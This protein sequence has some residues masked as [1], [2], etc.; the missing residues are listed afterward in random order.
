MSWS[1]KITILIDGSKIGSNL[2]NFPV[3]LNLSNSSGISDADLSLIF[4]E[5]GNESY[6]I[7][8][9]DEYGVQLP[10]EIENWDSTHKTAQLWVRVPS[11]FAGQD[12]SLSL[13]YD[14]T[15]PSN[16]EFVGIA[17]EKAIKLSI[18]VNSEGTYDTSKAY[19][20]C[21]IKESDTSY[22]MWYTGYDGTTW[23]ILYCTSNDGKT[24]SNFQ[25]VID[26]GSEG[27]HDANGARYPSVVKESNTLYKMWY[28]GRNSSNKE[29]VL[30]ATSTDGT[31]WSNFQR[32]INTGSEGTYDTASIYSLSVIKESDTSY[33]IWYGGS[34]GAYIRI[35]YATS[36]N[37]TSWSN[38]QRSIN[39]GSE[40]T[41]D[42]QYAFKPSVIKESSVSYKI[43]Y[44]GY[45]GSSHRIIYATSTDGIS[46]SNFQ[47]VINKNSEGTYDT[48]RAHV[49]FVIKE[50]NNL[51]KI[52]YAGYNGSKDRI[53]YATSEDG[54][55]WTKNVA[56][57][58]WDDNFVGVWHMS[59]EPTGGTGCILDSTSNQ[60]NGTP[61]GNMTASDLVDGKIGKALDFDGNDDYTEINGICSDINSNGN[62]FT[63]TF[64]IKHGTTLPSSDSDTVLSMHGVTGNSN[65]AIFWIEPNH[66]YFS[67]ILLNTSATEIIRLTSTKN[68]C[69]DNW[70]IVD[71][72]YNAAN[73]NFT[74]YID[75]VQDQ[76]GTASS[77]FVIESNGRAS[78]G[79]E[80]DAS[81][82][83]FFNGII[84]E[85]RVSKIA[86]SA[87]WIKATYYSNWDNLVTFYPPQ[88][89]YTGYVQK[90]GV[91]VA[92][93]V[94]LYKRD[95]GELI[96]STTSASG[97]G[98]FEIISE[99]DEYHFSVIL[100]EITDSY[101]IIASDK[102][103]P[104]T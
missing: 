8:I 85:V 75:G 29:T 93:P 97:N 3:L 69:D 88:F 58:V 80:Y 84:D 20:G 34:D 81:T 77:N 52:W 61:H 101:N 83:D 33:K 50:S 14:S 16:R 24:W 36:T 67:F 42:T 82:S 86:R 72:V 12:K 1:N 5:L 57:R 71:L 35:I 92:R 43:W 51:Y 21:V 41:Y 47:L 40:G 48:S 9:E 89:K 18:N 91:P 53:L 32:V 27:T 31:N 4:D 37:G 66:N 79:Q 78:I 56:N 38:F 46:W 6:K 26:K 60:N 94:H 39:I 74:S 13:Y 55:V 73:K 19:G 22:K 28:G 2:T 23:R 59:Q 11:L 65:R 54:K 62:Y 100:P 103:K 30:Y 10:I 70:H 96:G 87:D 25:L 44:T 99:Y 7:K 98:Y 63:S 95:T 104:G 76:T 68:V 15:K 64:A 49:P 90:G 17:S 102:I 45:D